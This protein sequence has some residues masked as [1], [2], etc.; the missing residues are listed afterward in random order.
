[1]VKMHQVIMEKNNTY[2]SPRLEET[3]TGLSEL[4]ASSPGDGVIEDVVYD[5]LTL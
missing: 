4:L 5:D 2:T 1:M 3:E